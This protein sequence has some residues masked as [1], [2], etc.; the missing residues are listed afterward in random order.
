MGLSP[1][2]MLLHTGV[3]ETCLVLGIAFVLGGVM[4][5]DRIARSAEALS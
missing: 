4:W 2:P 5:M 3:G 1:V